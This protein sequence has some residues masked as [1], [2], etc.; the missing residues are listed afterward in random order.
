MSQKLLLGTFHTHTSTLIHSLFT[1]YTCRVEIGGIS[2]LAKVHNGV[3]SKDLIDLMEKKQH[4]QSVIH[5]QNAMMDHLSKNGVSTSAPQAPKEDTVTPASIHALPVVSEAHSPCQL[6]VRLLRW[7]PGR[8]MASVKMLP[9]ESLADA[10]KFLGRLSGTLNLLETESLTAAKR[11]HQWDGKKTAD[12]RGF[13]QYIKD[14]RKREMVNSVLDA[15]QTELID[16]GVAD[17]FPKGLIHGDFNDA[18]ILV[19]ND[20]FVSGCIDFGDSVER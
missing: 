14:E 3:E 1:N 2:Y 4:E 13:V 12:L 6:V 16:S 20:L 17:R 10:G 11:Y 18:N 5:L 7:V 8:T 15:F 19:D 9:L